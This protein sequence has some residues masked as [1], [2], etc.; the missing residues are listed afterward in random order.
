YHKHSIELLIENA[1]KKDSIEGK[2][3][4]IEYNPE[5]LPLSKLNI[6]E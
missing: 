1:I 4:S 3:V 5:L 2:I 6:K